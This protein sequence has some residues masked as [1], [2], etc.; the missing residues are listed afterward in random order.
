MSDWVDKAGLVVA[1]S[2]AHQWDRRAQWL[3]DSVWGSGPPGGTG[4]DESIGTTWN[5]SES[6]WT[7]CFE[8][9][10]IGAPSEF[11]LRRLYLEPGESRRCCGVAMANWAVCHSPVSTFS[12]HSYP[13][14]ILFQKRTCS[15]IFKD[16]LPT[17][18]AFSILKFILIEYG[19]MVYSKF[20]LHEK[21]PITNTYSIHHRAGF[22]WYTANKSRLY[23]S[24]MKPWI[25]FFPC[26]W[27]H[28]CIK[29]VV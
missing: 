3:P 17:K 25:R 23:N 15:C 16:M 26:H 14:V 13:S 27:L 28:N 7:I 4:E 10:L 19:H 9:D 18:A 12:T 11:Y 1:L 5:A 29:T 2:S 8:E 20:L 22:I 24:D 21:L 6:Y